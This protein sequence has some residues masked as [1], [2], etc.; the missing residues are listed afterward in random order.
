M[1]SPNASFANHCLR[2]YVADILRGS[3]SLQTDDIYRSSEA[4]RVPG[5]LLIAIALIENNRRPVFARS[6]ENILMYFNIILFA[7]FSV[8][9]KN[10][11]LGLFQVSVATA[12]ELGDLSI[13]C[14]GGWVRFKRK[15]GQSRFSHVA[16]VTRFIRE[17]LHRTTN[18]RIAAR[19]IAALHR[20]WRQDHSADYHSSDFLWFLGEQ[21]NDSRADLMPTGF[22]PYSL[23]LSAVLEE[24]KALASQSRAA[25]TA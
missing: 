4:A 16:C 12:A 1:T 10:V 2:L 5:E 22:L 25:A 15:Q 21:Y 11:T 13:D 8:P 7:L 3:Q 18:T 17:L 14:V 6:I 20:L 19:Y 9:I 23:V 24:L